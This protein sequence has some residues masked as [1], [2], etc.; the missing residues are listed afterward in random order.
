MSSTKNYFCNLCGIF[1]PSIFAVSNTFRL[2]R[3]DSF[4]HIIEFCAVVLYNIDKK[5]GDI[6]WLQK[7]IFLN[8]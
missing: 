1:N 5:T 7:V 8:S 4:F 6:I 3:F 2:W